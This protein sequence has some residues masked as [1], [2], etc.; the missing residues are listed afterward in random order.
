MKHHICL[1]ILKDIHNDLCDEASNVIDLCDFAKQLSGKPQDGT[2]QS[3]PNISACEGPLIER[4]N[5]VAEKFQELKISN[6]LLQTNLEHILKFEVLA[7]VFYLKL[8]FDFH[9]GT[10]LY[11]LLCSFYLFYFFCNFI[12]FI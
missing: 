8:V 11:F 4:A 2:L 5:T 3:I 7:T 6:A 1:F 10:L 9:S 12:Y